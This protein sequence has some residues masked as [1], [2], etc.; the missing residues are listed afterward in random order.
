M[1]LF[2]DILARIFKIDN[3]I[4]VYQIDF[5]PRIHSNGI[6]KESVAVLF[7]AVGHACTNRREKQK[8]E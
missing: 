5:G 3:Q 7:M 6:L 2:L 1:L 8:S 4:N